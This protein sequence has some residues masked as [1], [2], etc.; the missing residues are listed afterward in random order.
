MGGARNT[1]MSG[2]DRGGARLICIC[3]VVHMSGGTK[4]RGCWC[5][6]DQGSMTVP[7]LWSISRGRGG[8]ACIRGNTCTIV[9]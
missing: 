8:P 5:W 6:P 4:G 1:H 3:Q 2:G 9:S 7:S